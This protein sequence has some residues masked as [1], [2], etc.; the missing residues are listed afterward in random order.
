MSEGKNNI[1]CY[2]PGGYGPYS[3]IQFW[4]DKL[5][6]EDEEDDDEWQEAADEYMDDQDVD[7]GCY[8]MSRE[9]AEKLLGTLKTLLEEK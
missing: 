8:Y 6:L 7:Y 3:R 2:S 5:V 4:A 9:E 1:F